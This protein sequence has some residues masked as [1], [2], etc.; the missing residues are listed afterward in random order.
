[1]GISKL[2]SLIEMTEDMFYKYDCNYTFEQGILYD[3][4][5][6]IETI[7]IDDLLQDVQYIIHQLQED[8]KILISKK[9]YDKVK[10]NILILERLETLSKELNT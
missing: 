6:Q 10:D 7:D 8:S 9:A 5:G 3:D 2:I 1:M 4:D